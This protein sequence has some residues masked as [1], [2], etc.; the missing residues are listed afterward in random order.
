MKRW[1]SIILVLLVAGL[2]IYNMIEANLDFFSLFGGIVV[3]LFVCIP[4]TIASFK[5]EGSQVTILI[6]VF[7]IFG[8]GASAINRLFAISTPLATVEI[9]NSTNFYPMP[10]DPNPAQ[11]ETMEWIEGKWVIG[12]G[13]GAQKVG[14]A[15]IAVGFISFLL[16][17]LSAWIFGLSFMPK[18][19]QGWSLPIEL[20]L[21]VVFIFISIHLIS[22]PINSTEMDTATTIAASA[23]W[24]GG[25]LKNSWWPLLLS[26]ISTIMTWFEKGAEKTRIPA[27]MTIVSAL[28]FFLMPVVTTV[29][30]PTMISWTACTQQVNTTAMSMSMCQ[31]NF[32]SGSLAMLIVSMA[33]GFIVASVMTFLFGE[34]DEVQ[35]VD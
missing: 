4:W 24:W 28:F 35:E 33:W 30:D 11:Q 31:E 6:C 15:G 13:E 1:S 14:L 34:E 10:E 18:K 21:A 19:I 25:F 7:I 20:V 5:S 26:A 17:L 23:Q 16:M 8:S 22:S 32:A 3:V 29:F 2:L 9:D 27:V 12:V